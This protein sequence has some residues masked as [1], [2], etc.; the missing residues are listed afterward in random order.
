[1]R[2]KPLGG[3]RCAWVKRGSRRG[4]FGVTEGGFC[5][6]ITTTHAG[7]TP[8][9]QL[10]YRHDSRLHPGRGAVRPLLPQVPGVD[11]YWRAAKLKPRLYLFPTRKEPTEQEKPISDKTVWTACHEAAL[12]AGLTKRIGPHTLRN[13]SAY[14]TTFQSV[15]I[16]KIIGAGQAQLA[17]VCGHYGL[18]APGA[19][20]QGD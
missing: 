4:N 13:A 5:D 12:R 9:T 19:A 20:P 18:L 10:Y 17:A 16:L 14:Y 8:A 15:F 7:G 1:V 2:T 6:P 3:G 11:E